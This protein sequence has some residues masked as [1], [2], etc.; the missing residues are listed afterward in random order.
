MQGSGPFFP[1]ILIFVLIFVM[2]W[3]SFQGLKVLFDTIQNLTLRN[4]LKVLYWTIPYASLF[5]TIYGLMNMQK[6]HGLGFW[7]AIGFNA[8]ITLF[9]TQLTIIL[10]IFG[11]DIYRSAAGLVAWVQSIGIKSSEPHTYMPERKKFIAQLAILVA[12]VPFTSFIYGIVKGK[13]N[14]KLH[15]HILTFPD[16]PEAFHGFTITQISD[17][18]AGSLDDKDAV[19]LGIDLINEQKSDLFLFTGDLV[20]N[21]A[22]EFENWKELFSKIKAPYGQFSVLGNHDYGDYI[23]WES[24]EAKQKNHENIIQHH[25][26]AGYQLLR[27][28]HVHIEKDGAKISLIGVQNW[29]HGFK[30]VGDLDR[31]LRGVDKNA[32]KILLSHDPTH[33]EHVVKTHPTHIHLTLSGH[34]H[35]MQMGVEFPWLKWSPVKYRYPRWAGMYEE[36]GKYIHINRG[37]GFL[38]FGGRVGIWPEV[39]VIELRRG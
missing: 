24:A 7:G 8:L 11:G 39:T 27:D 2:N 5:L 13:Y 31:A 30:K 17:I 36:N 9:F 28:E 26:A 32:F 21:E 19:S 15:K 37:F 4:I 25:A 16:L 23:A 38:G 12:A 33:F 10:V 34:T 1:V 3:Y 18:H 35:G 14:Y 29:G 20:N 6:N 22:I